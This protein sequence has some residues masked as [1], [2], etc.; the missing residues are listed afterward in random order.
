MTSQT[1][2]RIAYYAREVEKYTYIILALGLFLITA[3]AVLGFSIPNQSSLYLVTALAAIYTFLYH[4]F[5]YLKRPTATVAIID[6]VAFTSFIFVLNQITGGLDSPLFFLYFLPIISTR[7][8]LGPNVPIFITF[9]STFF[10]S[11]EGLL[12]SQ[13]KIRPE[14]ID[15]GFNA[16]Q[17]L[18][19]GAKM[20]AL[21]IFGIYTRSLAVE[22]SYESEQR[23]E[24]QRLNDQLKETQKAKDEFIF[25]ASHALRSPVVALRGGIS[26]LTR[27]NLGKVTTDQKR[28]LDEI[29]KAGERMVHLVD[30]LIDVT[31]IEHPSFVLKKEV[32]KIKDLVDEVI[33]SFQPVLS[34]KRMDL[35]VKVDDFSVSADRRKIAMVISNLVDNAIKYTPS[36][37]KVGVETK[38]DGQKIILS[39]TDT[40]VGI[41]KEDLEKV[42]GKFTKLESV[43]NAQNQSGL[44]LGLY[45]SKLIIERHGEKIWTDS[46]LGGGSK[47]SFTLERA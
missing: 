26:L 28:Y 46:S 41:N 43:L 2:Q 6:A 21:I 34:E 14:G 7:L 11:A 10:I 18:N 40:G 44:G 45:A 29:G 37:G 39:I 5:V 20:L 36:G 3:L 4:R 32:F 47:F 33:K 30:D 16:I 1:S 31:S 25:I 27:G 35:E 9:L 8:N 23:R 13:I 17:T 38:E 19:L 12:A 22:F 15:F 42:F 24:I